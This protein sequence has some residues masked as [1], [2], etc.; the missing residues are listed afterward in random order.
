VE[1][2][3]KDIRPRAILDEWVRLGVAHVDEQDC[4]CLNTGAFVPEKGFDEKAHYLGRSLRDHVAA[5]AR[6]LTGGAPALLERAVYYDELSESSVEELAEISRQLGNDALEAV[7]RR[8]LELQKR[9]AG[10]AGR[11]GRGGSGGS[12]ERRM[13]FGVYFYEEE[14]APGSPD[15]GDDDA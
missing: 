5:A 3:S 14:D 15:A 1:S 10:A 4:V 13:S 11:A 7:N 9:D 6:N 8:A 12:S 2:V